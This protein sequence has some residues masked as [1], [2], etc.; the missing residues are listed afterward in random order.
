V[1]HAG[2]EELELI[3]QRYRPLGQLSF[4]VQWS[5]KNK[6]VKYKNQKFII[7][8]TP[9]PTNSFSKD[10]MSKFSM[11]QLLFIALAWFA[12]FLSGWLRSWRKKLIA[13]LGLVRIKFDL[14]S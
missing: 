9:Y 10:C 8:T 12:I 4:I 1:N 7:F 11:S 5:K 3:C 14:S 2:T 6:T 13:N